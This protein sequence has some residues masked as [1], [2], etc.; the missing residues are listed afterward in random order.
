MG[1]ALIN[2]RLLFETQR[3]ISMRADEDEEEEEEEMLSSNN[4]ER[5][6]RL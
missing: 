3:K 5:R 6:S 1:P 2:F 4:T